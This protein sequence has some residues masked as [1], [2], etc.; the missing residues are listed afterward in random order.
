MPA[1]A[2]AES[3]GAAP[4]AGQR[5]QPAASILQEVEHQSDQGQLTRAC[6]KLQL[7]GAVKQKSDT[8]LFH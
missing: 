1:D 8:S 6:P 3:G 7:C 2:L 5:Q 4:E